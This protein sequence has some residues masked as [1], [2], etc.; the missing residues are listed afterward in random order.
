MS[1]LI[2]SKPGIS[3]ATRVDR[4]PQVM[5]ATGDGEPQETAPAEATPTR[6]PR[7]PSAPKDRVGRG[8][9]SRG[10]GGRREAQ[11]PGDSARTV[12][13]G[14]RTGHDFATRHRNPLTALQ[15]PPNRSFPKSSSKPQ[16]LAI[17]PG[18]EGLE[19]VTRSRSEGWDSRGVSGVPQAYKAP[20]VPL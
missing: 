18:A 9:L 7:F 2:R 16:V 1:P 20:S 12:T 15:S 4:E 6:W 3:K 5:G 19:S 17:N 10:V 13:N 11:P 8:T 14:R